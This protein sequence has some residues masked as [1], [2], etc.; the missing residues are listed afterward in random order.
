[1]TV[2]STLP[3]MM[4]GKHFSS[5]YSG[6]MVGAGAIRFALMG[7]VIAMMKPDREHGA[8]VELNPVLLGAILGETQE[9]MVKA[10]EFLC[11]P[12]PN[13]RSKE[14]GGRR[15]ERLGQFEYRVVNGRKY[16]QI[17]NEDDRREQNRLN[18]QAE[19]DRKKVKRGSPQARE[20]VYER[21]VKDGQ[22]P[23]I[24]R[25]TAQNLPMAQ[26]GRDGV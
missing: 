4:Y 3:S 24:L 18:K 22:E 21:Q 6:S 25:E 13:S 7:Y 2:I 23:D 11:S 1:M 20:R 26:I 16:M 19:R 9:D 15:L 17:R 12:D 8:V 10:I 5:M 14:S